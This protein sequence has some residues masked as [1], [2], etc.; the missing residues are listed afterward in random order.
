L[1]FR[2]EEDNFACAFPSQA[3]IVRKPPVVPTA[4]YLLYPIWQYSFSAPRDRRLHPAHSAA[5]LEPDCCSRAG[6]CCVG[7]RTSVWGSGGS[8]SVFFSASSSSFGFGR[9]AERKL[10]F[11]YE[12][13][14]ARE[15]YRTPCLSRVAHY[16]SSIVL[17]RPLYMDP[18]SACHMVP[19]APDTT[20]T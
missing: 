19:L 18:V 9:L 14:C 16:A 5:L 15:T 10:G 12:Q 8:A 11:G 20:L 1:D 4:S 6:A 7:M 3:E 2:N 13:R 17:L